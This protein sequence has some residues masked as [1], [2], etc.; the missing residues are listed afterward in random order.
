MTTAP[1]LPAAAPPLGLLDGARYR[2]SLDDGRSVWLDG[3]RVDVAT[4]PA[5]APTVDELARQLD[6]QHDPAL[7][8]A[9]T[10]VDDAT[11]RRIARGYH[12]P[13]DLDDLR[14]LRR[15]AEVWQ[16]ESFGQHGRSP[17]FMASIAVGVLDFAERLASADPRWG[18]NARA[19]YRHVSENDLVLTHALGDPQIDRSASVAENPD[20]ALRIV[21]RDDDGGLTI[22]GAKQ[23]TTLAPYAHEVLVYLSA[24]FAQREAEDFVLW[25]ALPINT[26]GLHVLAREPLGT[27]GHGHAHPLGA[28][29][30]EQDAMLFFDD[31]HVPADRVLLLRDGRLAL[32]GLGRINAW[33]QY[34]GQV[35]Y[36]ERLRTLLGVAT[37][38]AD[39]IGVA[40]FRNIQ[41]DL[42]ELTS[43]VEL[44]GHLLDAGEATARVT[45]A[46]HLA[47]GPTPAGAIWSAEVASRAVQIVRSIGQ[48][49]VL[50]QPTERDLAH[51]ELR[52]LLDRYMHGRGIGVEEKSRL[53]R[54]AWD[55]T[56]DSF[57]QRQDLYEV[58]HRGD[59][60][61]NRINLFRRHDQSATVERLR[62][63]IS[64]PL[65]EV[66]A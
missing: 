63:L 62:A 11:G 34:V 6:R 22:R 29:F 5:F 52:P 12:P 2:A 50:M 1:P 45:D 59:V 26:P 35:R 4:H 9:L 39:A 31:V 27:G 57:A 13:R 64:A 48:S 53:F 56:A 15:A 66:R 42:G 37:L 3:E 7:Q 36:R 46:G 40:E 16:S 54:L 47:P 10:V 23:L 43:Y 24:S 18:E 61:R 33:S 55:L 65:A 30:D 14:A 41:E 8:D 32:E 20:H 49:G 60:A 58:V 25:V 51:P 17:V 38:V 19:W 21:G 44:L 28:R